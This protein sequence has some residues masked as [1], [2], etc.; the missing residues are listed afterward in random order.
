MWHSFIIK[1]YSGTQE[2]QSIFRSRYGVRICN[3]LTDKNNMIFDVFFVQIQF[4]GYRRL[5]PL[6]SHFQ[7]MFKPI[8]LHTYITLLPPSFLLPPRT[9]I[10]RTC[11]KIQGICTPM[12]ASL[13]PW[14][15]N[16]LPCFI[17]IQASKEVISTLQQHLVWQ[18]HSASA[19]KIV[20]HRSPNLQGNVHN[21]CKQEREPVR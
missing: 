14:P 2:V 12:L 7:H 19:L 1:N 11:M 6:S 13:E 9:F 17:C 20:K 4:F 16:F 15:G 10:Y 5:P 3:M 8:C 21:T 18:P